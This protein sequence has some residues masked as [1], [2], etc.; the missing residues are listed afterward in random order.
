MPLSSA[1]A[2]CITLAAG[3]W[4][5]Q[6]R[7][8][9]TTSAAAAPTRASSDPNSPAATATAADA[10]PAPQV[11]ALPKAA[12]AEAIATTLPTTLTTGSASLRLFDGELASRAWDL[13]ESTGCSLF[14]VVDGASRCVDERVAEG[15]FWTHTALWDER[16]LA[17]DE[18]LTTFAGL[19]DRAAMAI[20]PA[21]ASEAAALAVATA[22]VLEPF[23]GIRPGVDLRGRIV[24]VRLKTR[25]AEARTLASRL[26]CD[27]EAFGVLFDGAAARTWLIR[28]LD[29]RCAADGV[30]RALA[31]CR[32]ASAP[33]DHV[34]H[35]AALKAGGA[36]AHTTLDAFA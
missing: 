35:A 18:V 32:A 1:L 5:W 27:D 16:P 8:A 3:V 12:E 30:A 4:W 15:D 33:R 25:D 7:T 26:A 14:V 20:M 24:P 28:G 19:Q 22:A 23:A 6:K 17:L 2:L 21:T 11:S 34:A 9:P 31:A 29:S 13:Y 36:I 10:A